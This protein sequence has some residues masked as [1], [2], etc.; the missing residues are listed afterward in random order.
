[1]YILEVKNPRVRYHGHTFKVQCGL[2]QR[3]WGV[4]QSEASGQTKFQ[5]SKAPFISQQ[6]CLPNRWLTVHRLAL[7]LIERLQ[8]VDGRSSSVNCVVTI[9]DLG[10]IAQLASIQT[11]TPPGGRSVA[12]NLGYLQILTLIRSTSQ[13]LPISKLR[14]R[15]YTLSLILFHTSISFAL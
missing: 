14:T 9:P 15:V 2:G 5:S 1:M 13:A 4:G 10:E 6:L 7:N 12:E 11:E 8:G 3:A